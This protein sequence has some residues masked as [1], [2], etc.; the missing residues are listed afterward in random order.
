MF[1]CT[2]IADDKFEKISKSY[3]LK[4]NAEKPDS[5]P[6]PM[7]SKELIQLEVDIEKLVETSKSLAVDRI[8]EVLQEYEPEKAE[9]CDFT[10]E[11][12]KPA[13]LRF[14]AH[15][16]YL[17]KNGLKWSLATPIKYYK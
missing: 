17:S 15:I 12:L 6:A 10:F 13:T 2:S 1:L 8:I 5:G 3:L 9:S 16:V 14:L 11:E 7:S 4:R